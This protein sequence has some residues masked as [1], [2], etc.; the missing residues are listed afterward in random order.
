MFPPRHRPSPASRRSSATTSAV[1]QKV[2]A[3]QITASPRPIPPCHED[4]T[5]RIGPVRA[6]DHVARA[7]EC[8]QFGLERTH[9]RALDE[10]A[11]RQDARDGVIDGAAEAAALGG[12]VD[13]RDRLVS[14]RA[15]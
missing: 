8:R 3:G 7:A 5:Q 9:F 13:E 14:R 15:C 12:D 4:E 11:M 6:A 10:L 2:K 1:A